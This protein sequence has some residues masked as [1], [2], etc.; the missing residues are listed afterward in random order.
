MGEKLDF[1]ELAVGLFDKELQYH[2]LKHFKEVDGPYMDKLCRNE[3]CTREQMLERMK[4]PGSNFNSSWVSN[5]EVLIKALFLKL[6]AIDPS[7][8]WKNN[9][10]ELEIVF[11]R[12]EFPEGIGYDNL[13]PLNEL[14]GSEKAN[15]VELERD[16]IPLKTIVKTPPPTWEIQLILE[17][18]GEEVR[19][20]TIFPG[21][22]APVFP[23]PEIQSEE[24]Y[25][26]SKTFWET[27]V[28]MVEEE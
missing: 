24:D 5:P 14:T 19:I 8:E 18:N 10:C 20:L 15:I 11:D 6:K 23:D 16:A 4:R 17:R 27:H 1:R 28:M 22:Y 12:E 9:R 2:V 26:T 21:K 3:I 7:V 25:L 13:I